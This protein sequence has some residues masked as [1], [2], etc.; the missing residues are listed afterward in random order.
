M[1]PYQLAKDSESSQQQALFC[2]VNKA[3]QVGFVSAK[4]ESYYKDY[5]RM[6]DAVDMV[7][8]LAWYHAI[9]N[10]GSR[11]DTARSRAIEG[12]RM[13]AEGVRP[14][15]LDTFWPLVRMGKGDKL[16]PYCGLYIEL[17]KPALKQDK[18][19]T[20]GLSDEQ[21]NFGQF[22][23]DQGYCC[24]AAYSWLEAAAILEWYYSL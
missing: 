22:C 5:K 3:I 19:P 24:E 18:N 12:G 15:V 20:N 4:V 11:G 9:P 13:K 14:G 23:I 6:P 7:P 8:E 21:R 16:M 2:Y 10:G 17:K 1:T